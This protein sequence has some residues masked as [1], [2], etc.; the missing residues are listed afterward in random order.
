[1]QT[2]L[3][4]LGCYRLKIDGDW[5][6]G[7]VRALQG[8]YRNTGQKPAD[9]QPSFAL[10]SDLFLHSGRV[11]KD[12]VIVKQPAATVA[13]DVGAGSVPG[14]SRKAAR[15]PRDTGRPAVAPPPDISAGIGIGGVF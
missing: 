1:M 14:S 3:R 11:C 4:R 12:P 6:K 5:G 13:S 9:D 15:R 8:Y 2:E 10:L 7:S